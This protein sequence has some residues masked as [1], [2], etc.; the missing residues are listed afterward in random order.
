MGSSSLDENHLFRPECRF[1]SLPEPWRIIHESPNFLVQMGLGPLVEGYALILARK[2]ISCF[3]ELDGTL[4]R[5]FLDLLT[6]VQQ[7]QCRIYR[8][9]LYFEHGRSGACLPEGQGEDLCYHAHFHL[10]P[11]DVPLAELVSKDFEL[12]RFNDWYALAT[13]YREDPVPYILVQHGG[14]I[15]VAWTPDKLPKRYLRTTLA[16]ALGEPVL[17][18]WVAFPS[19]SLVRAGRDRLKAGLVSIL[20]DVHLGD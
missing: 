18:D 10:I 6:L 2:H 16:S 14:Q 4:L 15:A 19:Y 20:S 9:S 8:H 11:S 3:A 1:C 5:E 7:A 17:A 12:S 13:R